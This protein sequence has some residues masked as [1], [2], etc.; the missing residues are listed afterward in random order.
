MAPN[1]TLLTLQK[2]KRD[3]F[4]N[5]AGPEPISDLVMEAGARRVFSAQSH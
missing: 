4:I 1:I 5:K 3:C 2:V